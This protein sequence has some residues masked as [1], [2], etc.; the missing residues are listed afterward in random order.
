MLDPSYLLHLARGNPRFK[1][2]RKRIASPPA[3]PSPPIADA[4]GDDARRCLMVST[5]PARDRPSS[6]AMPAVDVMAG[7]IARA[8]REIPEASCDVTRPRADG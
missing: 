7:D 2:G 8:E 3:G 1:A 6:M 4:F 5:K